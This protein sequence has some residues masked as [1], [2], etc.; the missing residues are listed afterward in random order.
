MHARW[1]GR[2][3]GRWGSVLDPLPLLRRAGLSEGAS[4]LDLGSGEGRFSIPAASV[5][6]RIHAIDVSEDAVRSLAE[7]AA[8][9][10][11]RNVTAEVG[12][13]SGDIGFDG[14]FDF[15]LLANVLHGFR[16]PS[17]E[18]VLEN[19]RRALRPGGRLLVVEFRPDVPSP[20]GPPNSIRISPEELEEIA[21]RI[22]FEVV[23]RFEPGPFHYAVVLRRARRAP[24]KGR[25]SSG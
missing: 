24:S 3:G 10:G 12:D 13:I 18:R 2:A 21:R 7:E 9:L 6:A 23:D 17:R 4:M 22:G 15:A 5:A 19:A 14:E 11:L 25:P 8:R 16:E 20:P 1:H